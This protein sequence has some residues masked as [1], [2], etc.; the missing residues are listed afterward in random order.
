MDD[1]CDNFIILATSA[2]LR[3]QLSVGWLLLSFA[4]DAGRFKIITFRLHLQG[5]A[6]SISLKIFSA[7]A[8][9][10]IMKFYILI[11]AT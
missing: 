10:F 7:T 4:F 9:H 6:K 3:L 2:I 8:W 1:L 11:N 5:A